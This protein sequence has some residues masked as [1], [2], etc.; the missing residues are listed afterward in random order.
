MFDELDLSWQRIEL[1]HLVALRAVDR[2]RSFRAA[3]AQL[4]YSLSALSSQISTL[5]RL[6]GQRLVERPGGRRTISITPAGR[7][8]LE[9]G[10]EIAARLAAARAD[11]EA[12]RVKRP[13]LRLGIYQSVAV[14]LLPGILN[15]LAATRPDLALELIEQA[16]DGALQ[17]L[18]AR[19]D[20]DATFVALPT[21]PG[22][23][24]TAHLLDEPY[25]L[26]VLATGPLGER[27]S[28]TPDEIVQYPLID[29]RELRL[30][31]HPWQRLP[32]QLRPTVVARSDDNATIHALV[33]AGIGVALLPLLSVDRRDTAVRAIPVHPALEPRR[34]AL[35][36][37]RDRKPDGL[38]E[39]L[40]AAENE[41]RLLATTG[42]SQP[43]S[44][45]H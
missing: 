17:E 21:A 8:L 22:R 41:T 13:V 38:D 23:F 30:V 20:V 26:L 34:V 11:L 18:V 40:D 28:I 16:D 36:W 25:V 3:A 45:A 31:H 4:G 43:S 24:A 42:I 15:R 1:R 27:D 35:A 12:I 39:I 14:R 9:H 2:G 5:E 37:H 7:R 44:L 6:V 32:R 29:Y 10:E 33:A 19:G